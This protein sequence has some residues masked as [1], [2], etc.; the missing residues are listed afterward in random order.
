[1][2]CTENCASSWLF[3]TR[4]NLQSEILGAKTDYLGTM[5]MWHS[6]IVKAWHN[7]C[8]LYELSELN[9]PE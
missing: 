4:I 8:A 5:L 7:R 2:K 6:G 1:M 9:R 3:F